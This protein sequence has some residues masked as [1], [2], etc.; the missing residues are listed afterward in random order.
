V[1]DHV[2]VRV[3][4]RVESERLYHTVLAALGRRATS[5]GR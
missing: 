3:S 4:V 2:T 5:R 1:F